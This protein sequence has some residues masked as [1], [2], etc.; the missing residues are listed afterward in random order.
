MDGGNQD[1]ERNRSLGHRQRA[2]ADAA[3]G[4]A[5]VARCGRGIRARVLLGGSLQGS[6]PRLCRELSLST[7]CCPRTRT[8]RSRSG[9][10]RRSWFGQ[11]GR[12]RSEGGRGCATGRSIGGDRPLRP[13]RMAR[14][15]RR[16]LGERG[17]I[18]L[19]GRRYGEDL[20]VLWIDSHPDVGTPGSQYAGYHAMAGAV[21]TGHGDPEVLRLLP[22][23]L[24]PRR[25]LWSAC[26]PGPKTI[27]PNIA[28]WGIR[29]FRPDDLR[30]STSAAARVA[31]GV[32]MLRVLPSI[33]MSM[34]SIVTRSSSVWCGA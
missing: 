6:S 32:G 12:D 23:T 29:S 10:S 4:L 30:H 17:A 27:F 2:S 34:S 28:R 33:S 31:Q 18:L 8:D 24:D 25:W 7:R 9:Q 26:I 20:A 22:A 14:A 5:A 13:Q 16:V 19:A 11:A 15:R 21:L 3:S 1:D